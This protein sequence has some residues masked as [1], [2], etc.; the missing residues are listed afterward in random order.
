MS[1]LKQTQ[2]HKLVLVNSF[3]SVTGLNCVEGGGG[4]RHLE[5]TS[6]A[7]PVHSYKSC[8]MAHGAKLTSQV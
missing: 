7:G 8:S 1:K 5:T 2:S 6:E 4:A 3:Y